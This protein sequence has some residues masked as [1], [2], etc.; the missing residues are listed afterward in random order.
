[1]TTSVT[2]VVCVRLPLTPVMVSVY[3]P[4]GVVAASVVTERV[5]VDVAGLVLKLPPAPVGR[6]LTLNVTAPVKPFV[7]LIVKG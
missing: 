4:A 1:M 2:V 3:E 7:G 5:E 6:P